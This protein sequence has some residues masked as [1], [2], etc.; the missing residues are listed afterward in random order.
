[1][2][3]KLNRRAVIRALLALGF[4]LAAF[5]VGQ[6]WAL[7]STSEAL[8]VGVLLT[9]AFGR[10][11]ESSARYPSATPLILALTLIIFTVIFWGRLSERNLVLVALL[12][13]V[14]GGV[15]KTE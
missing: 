10:S 9:V 3:S 8:T 1:M 14:V 13:G 11:P 4:G 12:V 5:I 2:N 6:A 15:L 7:L